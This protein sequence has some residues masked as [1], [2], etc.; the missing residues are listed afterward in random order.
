MNPIITQNIVQGDSGYPLNYTL[1]DNSGNPIDLTGTTVSIKVQ[2]FNQDSVKF[3]GTLTL[4][5]PASGT[6]HYTVQPTD[7]DQEGRYK[8]EITITYPSSE[9]LSFVNIVII[10]APKLPAA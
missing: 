2:Q 9:T 8:A 10:A 1:Q 4:D 6:C 7:F 3:S 5:T